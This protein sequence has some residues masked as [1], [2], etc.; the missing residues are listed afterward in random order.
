MALLVWVGGVPHGG[1]ALGLGG[2]AMGGRASERSGGCYRS[3]RGDLQ[4][5]ARACRPGLPAAPTPLVGGR[6][7]LAGAGLVGTGG[8]AGALVVMALLG[9]HEGSWA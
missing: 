4:V 6:P 7:V 3:A 9:S 5:S 2:G 8:W 1:L